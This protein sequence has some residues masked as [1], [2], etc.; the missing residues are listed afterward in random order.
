M[1]TRTTPLDAAL[2]LVADGALLG[3]GGALLKRKPVAFLAALGAAG[4]RDLRAVSFLA[5]LDA[6]LL[7]AF[8]ALA[9]LHCGYVGFEQLGFAPAV[10]AATD[11]GTVRRVDYGELIFAAGL[12]AALAGLPFLPT[13]GG[14][15]SDV[16]RDLGLRTVTCPYSGQVLLAAPAIRPDV[17]VLHAEAADEEGNVLG[18]AHADFLFD[19]DANLARA[20]DRVVVTV[21]RLAERDEL[22][23]A[24]RRT[25]LFG[26]EVDAVVVLPGGAR[27]TAV[28]GSYGPDLAGLERYLALAGRQPERAVDAMRELVGP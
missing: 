10:T 11:A 28:P 26:F 23:A 1:R 22:V 9:E 3:V 15:G 12:R 25:L 19:M 7:A 18:P 24:N 5:S 20:S 2:G 13:R 17:T 16:V 27:P 8:G 21:E 4:R 14:T 6:E